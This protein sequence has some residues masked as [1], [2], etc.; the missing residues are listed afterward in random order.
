MTHVMCFLHCLSMF[1]CMSVTYPELKHLL[2]G[3]FVAFLVDFPLGR[4]LCKSFLMYHKSYCYCR[5]QL[6]PCHCE[7]CLHFMSSWGDLMLLKSYCIYCVHNPSGTSI[8]LKM[9]QHKLLFCPRSLSAQQQ[10]LKLL[11]GI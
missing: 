5:A 11:G 4:V 9:S 7:T 3:T 8:L 6:R 2:G 1:I 10:Y